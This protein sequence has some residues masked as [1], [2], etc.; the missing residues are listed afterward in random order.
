MRKSAW[1]YH[2]LT[3]PPNFY[4]LNGKNFRK[5]VY[6]EAKS[7]VIYSRV[8]KIKIASFQGVF[9]MDIVIA[10]VL[11]LAVILFSLHAALFLNWAFISILLKAMEKIRVV[12]R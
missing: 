12:H 6:V 3:Q 10:M 9:Q 11:L 4:S 7:G 5:V 1:F 2:Y 8:A